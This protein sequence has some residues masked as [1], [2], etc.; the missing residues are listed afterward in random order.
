[1]PQKKKRA[2]KPAPR[3]YIMPKT[4]AELG[5]DCAICRAPAIWFDYGRARKDQGS[6]QTV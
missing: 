5:I 6:A 4:A 2:K 3:E 1:M